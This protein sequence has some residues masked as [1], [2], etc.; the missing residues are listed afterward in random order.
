MKLTEFNNTTIAT[1]KKALSENY[2]LP[3]NVGSLSPSATNN[4]LRKVRG[5][6]AETRESSDFYSSQ[7]NPA[8][9]KLMFMSQALTKQMNEYKSRSSTRIVV[10]NE[11]VEKSQVVL[12]AQDMVD[13]IQKMLEQVSDMLVK[14]MPALVDSV[15]SEIGVNE[16]EQFSTQASEALTSLTAALTQSKTTLQGALGVITGQ[17][18]G[19]S[20]GDDTG[21][22]E[23]EFPTDEMPPEEEEFPT[24]EMPPEEEEF[25]EEEPLAAPTSV[26]RARR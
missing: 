3:F 8:Y 25:P 21:M 26:G 24:D 9:M 23:E 13:S 20:F 19:E 10:E 17:G 15:Q 2:N 4:M 22:P 16:S 11:E 7:N 12:A 5:L 1:A 18:G 6:I 14:E